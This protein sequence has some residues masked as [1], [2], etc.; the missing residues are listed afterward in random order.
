VR[1]SADT[2]KMAGMTQQFEKPT[3]KD[4]LKKGT[5]H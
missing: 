4:L 2:N 5:T 3:M 1:A